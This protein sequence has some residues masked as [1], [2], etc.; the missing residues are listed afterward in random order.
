MKLY[1]VAKWLFFAID[2]PRKKG[3]YGARDVFTAGTTRSREG[4]LFSPVL[5]SDRALEMKY[6]AVQITGYKAGEEFG[7]DNGGL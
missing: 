6:E 1:L 2:L 4:L 5:H 3:K 7:R